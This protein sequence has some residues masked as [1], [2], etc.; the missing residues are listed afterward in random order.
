M[1]LELVAILEDVRDHFQGKFPLE[2]VCIEINSGCRCSAYNAK[3]GGAKDS[4]HVKGMAAD[5]V[6]WERWKTAQ[7]RPDFVA[8]YFEKAY[9]LRYGIGRYDSFTH[10]DVRPNMARWDG[11]KKG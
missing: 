3:V 1:D 5:I 8:D 11:R 10:L 7:V 4:Q 9:A 2:R 6:I